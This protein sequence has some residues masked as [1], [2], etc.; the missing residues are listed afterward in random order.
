MHICV[1]GAGAIGATASFCLLKQGHD[2]TLVDRMGGAGQGASFGNGAQLSYSYVAPLAEPSIWTKWPYYLFSSAS[3][4]TLRPHIDAAQWRWLLAFLSA[5]R[6][7]RARQTTEELLKLA[8]LSKRSLAAILEAEPI[9][10]HY[11][12]AG[13]LVMFEDK[14]SL[15]GAREQVRFQAGLGCRQTV[16]GMNGCLDVEPALAGAKRDWVGGVYTEDEEVGDCARFC[17]G[18][19]AAMGKRPNFHFRSCTEVG[20]PHVRDGRLV[21]IESDEGR[22]EADA[23][24]LAMGVES[25]GFARRLGFSLPLYPL[26]GYSITVPVRE[27]SS[28]PRTSITDLSRKVVY[29]RVGN[30]IRV[31]GRVEL[32]GLDG[33]IPERAIDELRTSAIEMFPRGLDFSSDARIAPWAGFRPATPTGL[34]II[35]PSPVQGLY[36]N[37]GHGSLGWTLACGS[38]ALLS[39]HIAGGAFA[40]NP[41]PYLLRA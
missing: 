31:A 18:L 26:K 15:E 24:V 34:P 30:H 20:Q 21:A 13:K 23:F 40:I 29:A 16:L 33:R 22:I 27:P 3:P 8:F 17:E 2:V 5:C 25:A 6:T 37:V 10:F 39:Q 32:V 12:R 11:R 36:L 28:A 35:G 4:L 1:L 41:A 38:A 7:S 14:A 19:V 9:D